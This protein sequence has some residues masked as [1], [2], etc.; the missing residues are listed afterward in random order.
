MTM[1]ATTVFKGEMPRVAR[2][3]LPAEH[4]GE[5]LNCRLLSGD[6]E[7][8]KNFEFET[9]LAKT[10]QIRTIFPLEDSLGNVVWL[11]WNAADLALG[12]VEVDVAKSTSGS[13]GRVFLTGLDVPRWTNYALASSTGSSAYPVQTRPLGVPSPGSAPTVTTS[14]PLVPPVAVSD[15]FT[16]PSN[17]TLVPEF[18]MRAGTGPDFIIRRA[19][20]LTTGGNP[21]NR[22]R[23]TAAETSTSNLGAAYAY[24]DCGLGSSAAIE[25]SFDFRFDAKQ[26]PFNECNAQCYVL[27]NAQGEGPRLGFNTQGPSANAAALSLGTSWGNG[28]SSI[29]TTPVTTLPVTGTWYKITIT[30]TRRSN[31]N[32]DLRMVVQAAPAAAIIDVTFDNV[33]T[34]GGFFGHGIGGSLNADRGVIEYS[35]DNVFASGTQN[36]TNDP[37]DDTTTSYVYTYVNDI[38]EESGP[39]PASA[40]ISRDPGTQV[41]VAI[42]TGTPTG[43]DYFIAFK[44]LYRA[45]TTAVGT[46]FLFVTELALATP[47]FSDTLTDAELGEALTTTNYDLPPSD[48]RGIIALPN[49]IYAG[50]RQDINELCLSAQGRPHAWP[51]EFRLSTDEPIVAIGNIDTVLVIATKEFSYT[52]A[53][54]EPGNYAMTKSEVRQ[55]CVSKRGCKYLQGFGWCFPSPDGMVAVA[56]VGQPQLITQGLFTRREWQRLSPETLISAV[57]DDRYFGFYVDCDGLERGILLDVRQGSFGKVTLAFHASA[58]FAWA[59]TDTLYVVLDDNSPPTTASPQTDGQVVPVTQRAVYKF[60]SYCADGTLTK[61]L[62]QQWRSK[63]WPMGGEVPTMCRI[64][65]TDFFNVRLILFNQGWQ[66]FVYDVQNNKPFRIPKPFAIEDF[67]EFAIQGTSFVQDIQFGY[68]AEDFEP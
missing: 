38:G 67:F 37:T 39:S 40:T 54:T 62:P 31:G 10:G 45:V 48:L 66:Y 33:P 6:L 28:G 36:P 11:H 42:P 56:G 14:I 50:F 9:E 65:A 61:Y 15:D 46:E 41:T 20:I 27:C 29:A 32:F 25:Y 57:H 17:W 35:V 12:A 19:Q 68:N 13:D 60:D 53:G 7:A 63:K 49:E 1:P 21:D 52:A 22:L 26:T 43:P 3:K 24:R 47:T 8:F 4:A 51:I 2:R 59:K 16:V 5:A 44:R 34:N 18:N 64:R 58:A 23:L 55:G 30:G